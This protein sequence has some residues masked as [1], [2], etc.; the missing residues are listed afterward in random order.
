MSLRWHDISDKDL[1]SGRC[2]KGESS[3]LFTDPQNYLGQGEIFVAARIHICIHLKLFQILD[4]RQLLQRSRSQADIIIPILVSLFRF[5]FLLYPSDMRTSVA[6]PLAL[7]YCSGTESQRMPAN[8]HRS[9]VVSGP[10]NFTATARDYHRQN[11]SSFCP[12]FLDIISQAGV[13]I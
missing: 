1:D 13:N 10:S 11:I 6:P 3:A 7:T 8:M 5:V 12:S 4:S 9:Q 2:L